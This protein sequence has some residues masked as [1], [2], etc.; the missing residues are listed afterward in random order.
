MVTG[1]YIAQAIGTI[2][3]A[4]AAGKIY[5]LIAKSQSK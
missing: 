2:G 5:H 3:C 4:A 1:I